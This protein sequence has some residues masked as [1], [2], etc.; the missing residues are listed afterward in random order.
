MVPKLNQLFSILISL[1]IILN[2]LAPATSQECPYPCY[3]PPTATGNNPPTPTA[4]TTTPP[5]QTV[6]YPPPAFY[7]PPSGYLPYTPPY[8][9][10][11]PPPPDP[12][13][14]KSGDEVR[15]KVLMKVM[16]Q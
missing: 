13:R 7:P 5:Y 8:F 14:C 15:D 10:T 6:S 11:A 1:S 9:G 2:F 12:M 16:Q 4:T 3:P